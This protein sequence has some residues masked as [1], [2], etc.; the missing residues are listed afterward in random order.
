MVNGLKVH[1]LFQQWWDG[2]T[3]CCGN[4]SSPIELLLL[5]ALRYI[6]RKCTFDCL[7][8]VSFIS[9][10]THEPF[11]LAFITYGATDLYDKHVIAPETVEDA[12]SHMHEMGIA[13]FDGAIGSMDATHVII[14][15]C[16]FGVRISHL[17]HKFKKNSQNIQ[18][19]GKSS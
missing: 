16:R 1:P 9:R 8:E 11:F 19:C 13:G 2:C 14:E 15:N 17:G 6:G 12:K 18:Y 4:P 7:E 10:K 3:D 5:G